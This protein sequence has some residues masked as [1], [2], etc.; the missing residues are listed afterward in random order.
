MSLAVARYGAHRQNPRGGDLLA[1]VPTMR[2]I[3][4]ELK[5]ADDVLGNEELFMFATDIVTRSVRYTSGYSGPTFP[6]TIHTTE[7]DLNGVVQ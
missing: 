6:I 3:G 1:G 7:G 4:L 5:I 2:L